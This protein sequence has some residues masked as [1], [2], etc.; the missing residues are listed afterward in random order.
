MF[1]YNF[2]SKSRVFVIDDFYEDP[3]AVREF[4]LKQEFVEGGFGRG[5]IGRRSVHQY[6]FPGL[7]ERF[8]EVMGRKL[9]LW[10]EHGMNGRFQ[11]CYA[12]E[13]LVYHCDEQN[14]A[15]AIYLTPDPPHSCGTTFWA[16]KYNKC[17]SSK[18]FQTKGYPFDKGHLDKTSLEVVD[19]VGNVF[20]RL[21]IWDASLVHS[22]SEYCGEK[23]EDSR[24]FQIFFF[25]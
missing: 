2:N 16:H 8:E 24:F 12:Y 18:E 9:T 19:I 1:K 25:D 14:W 17:R 22:A 3:M 13:P 6:L 15:A 10:H 11:A 4:A 7:K 5:F 21:V 23:M 20:N